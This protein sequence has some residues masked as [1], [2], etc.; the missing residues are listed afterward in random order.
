M[1]VA[2]IVVGIIV[3]PIIVGIIVAVVVGVLLVV[4]LHGA[5]LHVDIAVLHIPPI[6]HSVGFIGRDVPH[7]Y[8][9]FVVI[10]LVD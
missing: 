9:I 3:I 8:Y 1:V 2:A 7:I 10:E 6:L 5:G 4:G